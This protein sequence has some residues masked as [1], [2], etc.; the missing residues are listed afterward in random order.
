METEHPVL[1]QN[2][3][4]MN[5]AILVFASILSLHPGA[6]N[7]PAQEKVWTNPDVEALRATSPISIIGRDIGPESPTTLPNAST[8][9]AAPGPYVMEQ[10]PAWYAREIEILRDEI[11][12]ADDQIEDIRKIRQTGEGISGAIP[13]GETAPGLTPEATIEV[14]ESEKQELEAGI[15]ELQDRARQNEIDREA[16]R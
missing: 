4:L 8:S 7:G 12:R 15:D 9:A 16:W 10:D 14:L 13:L 2:G 3:G 1:A 6:S 5:A 11:A